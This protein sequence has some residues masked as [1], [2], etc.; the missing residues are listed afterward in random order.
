[1][2]LKSRVGLQRRMLAALCPVKFVGGLYLV[3]RAKARMLAAA[4]V[5]L[6][7]GSHS[8]VEFFRGPPTWPS[9]DECSLWVPTDARRTQHST[10]AATTLCT[11]RARA[12]AREH[13]IPSRRTR[14]ECRR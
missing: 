7:K 1:M 13:R 9:P 11:R 8:I 2:Q 12:D 5:A 4:G 10:R 3:A 6:W 14:H